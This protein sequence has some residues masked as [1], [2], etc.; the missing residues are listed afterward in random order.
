MKTALLSLALGLLAG[1][2]SAGGLVAPDTA[3]APDTAA[4]VSGDWS[5]FYAGLHYGTGSVEAQGPV[6]R[7][8]TD[9]DAYGLHAGYLRDFGRHVLG[10][11]LDYDRLDDD[12][13]RSGDMLRL[14]ARAGMDLGRVMPYLTLGLARYSD[15]DYSDT[16][17]TYG[18][19][20]DFRVT[21]RV[22]LGLDYSRDSID[23][24]DGTGVDLDADSIRLRASFRF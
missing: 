4:T 17:L 10:A 13:D 18:L 5:G 12:D 8:E 14:R 1:T 19:G 3:P 6:R 2:A 7:Q 24:V 16:G 22:V 15:D 20:A 9:G 11:E 23:D 21:E